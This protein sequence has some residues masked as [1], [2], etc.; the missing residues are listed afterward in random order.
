MALSI[1]ESDDEEVSKDG[2][3]SVNEQHVDEEFDEEFDDVCTC[4]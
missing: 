2:N 1:E 3:D 4:T